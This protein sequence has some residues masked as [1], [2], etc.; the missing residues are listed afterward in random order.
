MKPRGGISALEKR[1]TGIP[2]QSGDWDSM[3]ALPRA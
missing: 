2:W 1:G 3:L